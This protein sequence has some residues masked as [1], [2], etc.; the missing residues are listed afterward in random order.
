MTPRERW[1]NV[2]HG[3]PVDHVPISFENFTNREIPEGASSAFREIQE[4]IINETCYP[5]VVPVPANRFLVTPPQ[6]MKETHMDRED[7]STITDVL[8]DT[9]KGNLTA[10]SGRNPVSDTSWIIKYPCENL[11]DIDKIMSIPSETPEGLVTPSFDDLPEDFYQRGFTKCHISSPFVCV[12]AMMSYEYF[13]ELCITEFNLIEELTRICL[14]RTMT[15]LDA[16]LAKR[17]VEYI[18]M[19]GCEWLTPPMGSP[20]LYEKLVQKYEE[21]LIKRIHEGGAISHVHCHGNVRSTLEMIIARG[22]DFTEPVEPPPD[23]DITFAEAKQ[24]AA[25]RITLGGNLESRILENEN[26]K[27]AETAAL[28]AFDGGKERMVYQTTA[29][30]IGKITPRMLANYHRVINVWEQNSKI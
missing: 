11:E 30:P 10:K 27:V 28:A 25:G 15:I 8:I 5:V 7:G 19:G 1:L 4:R 13:L 23:G 14:D 6:R 17:N 26:E 12:A 16:V 21:P 20:M 24:L 3:K 22:A 18:W 29:G 2:M 9:P